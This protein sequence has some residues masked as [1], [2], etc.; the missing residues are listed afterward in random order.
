LSETLPETGCASVAGAAS[1]PR[2]E[3]RG[4]DDPSVVTFT[5]SSTDRE[6][7]QALVL[8][9]MPSFVA[10]QEDLRI[11]HAATAGQ[12]A[13]LFTEVFD[14]ES[15]TPEVPWRHPAAEDVPEEGLTVRF[16]MVLRDPRGGMDWTERAL[17][18]VPA[19]ADP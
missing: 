5:T 1:F 7:Y 9:E 6:T 17:C 2:V 15:P 12:F 4:E 19:P 18:V 14:D 10:R 8:G 3:Q 16:W 11:T 13:R